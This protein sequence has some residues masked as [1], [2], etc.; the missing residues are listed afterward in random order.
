MTPFLDLAATLSA[1]ALMVL[2]ERH[3]QAEIR[4]DFGGTL[5]FEFGFYPRSG[6]WSRSVPSVAFAV[7]FCGLATGFLGHPWGFAHG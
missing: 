7:V 5:E 1:L 4:E 3:R 2:G 6:I